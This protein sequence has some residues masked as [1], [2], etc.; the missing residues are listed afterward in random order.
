MAVPGEHPAA[1]AAAAAPPI[2]QTP[3]ELGEFVRRNNQMMDGM[4]QQ[5]ETVTAQLRAAER[6]LTKTADQHA[7]SMKTLEAN[8]EEASAGIRDLRR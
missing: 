3:E 7:A 5:V 6:Q 8:I 2:P 4:R 1:A